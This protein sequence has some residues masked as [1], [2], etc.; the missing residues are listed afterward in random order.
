MSAARPEKGFARLCASAGLSLQVLADLPLA[1]CGRTATPV[2]Y[3]I[4]LVR[5]GLISAALSFLSSQPI[6][7][8]TLPYRPP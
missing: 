8:V 5:G 6:C 4:H 3:T 7:N 1:L 2:V